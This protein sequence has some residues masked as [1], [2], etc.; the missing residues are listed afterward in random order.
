MAEKKKLER[1]VG[2]DHSYLN[3]ARVRAALNLLNLCDTRFNT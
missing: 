1:K 3:L 2:G